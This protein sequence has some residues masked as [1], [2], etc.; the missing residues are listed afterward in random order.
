[1]TIMTEYTA[2]VNWMSRLYQ[3]V[4]MAITLSYNLRKAQPVC[5]AA[6]AFSGQ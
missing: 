2:Q 3:C 5:V 6:H 1:M 4:L